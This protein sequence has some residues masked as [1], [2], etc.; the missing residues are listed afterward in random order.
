MPYGLLPSR[1]QGEVYVYSVKRLH[2]KTKHIH[3]TNKCLFHS[4][5][6]SKNIQIQIK[7]IYKAHTHTHT[8]MSVYDIVQLSCV[9][10]NSAVSKKP[11][12]GGKKKLN[13]AKARVQGLFLPLFAFRDLECQVDKWALTKAKVIQS[14]F[15]GRTLSNRFF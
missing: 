10:H 12:P 9:L 1:K 2:F 6:Q 13:S 15:T 3:K 7:A 11:F 5:L 4:L 8:Q 14:S